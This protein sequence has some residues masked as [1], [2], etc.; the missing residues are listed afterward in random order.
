[1]DLRAK[2]AAFCRELSADELATLAAERNMADVLE[3]AQE[4][5]KEGKINAQLEAK[6]DL[7]DT[8]LRSSKRLGMY[9]PV[10]RGFAPLPGVTPDP[11]ARWW[12]CPHD[13]C[14]GRGRVRPD[15]AAPACT[16]T[17]QV[18]LSLPL[19]G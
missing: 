19:P 1:M 5:V 8:M 12:A 7:L 2:I 9:P 10:L 18:L 4:A 13:W 17:G 11:G 3:N 16:M 6:L 15:Q 14:A